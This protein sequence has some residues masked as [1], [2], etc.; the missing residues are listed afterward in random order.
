MTEAQSCYSKCIREIT[1]GRRN[2]KNEIKPTN[3]HLRK[4]SEI[5]TL[6]SYCD[7]L[8]IKKY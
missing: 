5:P 4:A 6:K 2:Y 1:Q 7:S 8:K 3:L